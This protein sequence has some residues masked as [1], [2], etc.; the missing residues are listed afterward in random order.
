MQVSPDPKTPLGLLSGASISFFPEVGLLIFPARAL[1]RTSNLGNPRSVIFDTSV[2][3]PVSYEGKEA[4]RA[5]RPFSAKVA[6]ESQLDGNWKYQYND[7]KRFLHKTY[8]NVDAKY[9]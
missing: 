9:L 7:F 4:L 3:S 8:N 1:L 6:E 2:L 5:R